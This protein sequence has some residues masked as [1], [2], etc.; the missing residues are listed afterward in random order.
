MT[1][2]KLP[3]QWSENGYEI[4]EELGHGSYGS[5]YKLVKDKGTE[6]EEVSA[7]KII[8]WTLDNNTVRYEFTKDW[9]EARK[10]YAQRFDQMTQEVN[11]LESFVGMKT[12]VQ[13]KGSCTEKMPEL[14]YWKLYI[15]MEY[16][17]DLMDFADECNGLTRKQI[18]KLG[19][20]ICNALEVCHAKNIIHRDIKPANIMV[21]PKGYFK[22]GDFGVARQQISGSMTVIGSYDFMAPEVYKGMPYDQTADIY[23]LGMVLYYL[24]NDFKLPFSEIQSSI[25]RINRR[26]NGDTEWDWKQKLSSW[27]IAT[28]IKQKMSEEILYD[29]VMTACANDPKARYQSATAMKRDLMICMDKICTWEKRKDNWEAANKK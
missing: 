26:M 24:A 11:L 9:D 13:L 7:L 29:T 21:S 1:F 4:T 14:N 25:D 2:P 23:S 12:I 22:L 17:K 15:Q 20:D 5:V 16:L 27:G 28:N 8:N 10:S 18:V 6:N 19:I 3:I